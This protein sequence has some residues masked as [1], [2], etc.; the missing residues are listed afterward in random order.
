M[1]ANVYTLHRGDRER[2]PLPDE[3]PVITEDG[4]RVI[5]VVVIAASLAWLLGWSIGWSRGFDA[6]AQARRAYEES[7]R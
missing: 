6:G 5:G 3:R 7:V 4:W 1:R 2:L